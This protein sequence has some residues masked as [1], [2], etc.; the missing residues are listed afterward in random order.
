M[1]LV[2]WDD[3]LTPIPPAM[4]YP[5]LALA[6]LLGLALLMQPQPVQSSSSG[7]PANFTGGPGDFGT[8]Q[9]CHGGAPVNSGSGS[10]SVDAPDSF[11][12]GQTYTFTVTV[13]NTTPTQFERVQGFQLSVQDAEGSPV[14]M[15]M[16]TDPI[17]TTFAPGSTTHIT[18][19]F[20]GTS[21]TSWTMEWTA[22]ESDDAPDVATVYVAGNAADGNESSS[23]DLIYTTSV[24]MQRGTSSS[25]GMVV[26]GAFALAPL[27]PNPATGGLVRVPLSLEKA[28][29]VTIEVVDALG[30]SVLVEALGT[31]P[32]GSLTHSVRTDGLAP[33]VYFVRVATS[34]GA[35]VRPLTVRG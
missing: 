20:E 28:L 25:E 15:V 3:F 30:R 34:E 12:P 18:H 21:L 9:T 16:V 2:C 29:A 14:G 19:T 1:G 32:A 13:D 33:G 7:A 11:M 27:Y 22:P 5:L 6:V 23:G 8:C 10:V 4:R 35:L 17:H 26:P 31:V 24:A